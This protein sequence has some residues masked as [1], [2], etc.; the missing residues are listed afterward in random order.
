MPMQSVCLQLV[1]YNSLTMLINA[2]ACLPTTLFD[3]PP[4]HHMPM[5]TSPCSSVAV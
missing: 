3:T 5:I 1:I 2:H 4:A